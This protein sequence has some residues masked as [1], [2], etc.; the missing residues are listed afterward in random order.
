VIICNMDIDLRPYGD[1]F[2]LGYEFYYCRGRNIFIF[3]ITYFASENRNGLFTWN[4]NPVK[5]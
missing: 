1:N 3:K 5:G 2:C 4:V